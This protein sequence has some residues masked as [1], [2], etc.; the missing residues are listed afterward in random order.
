VFQPRKRL[1]QVRS[2]WRH[3]KSGKVKL[4]ESHWR[5]DPALG[6]VVKD[7]DMHLHEETT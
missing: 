4:I 1:H 6:V 7:Y 5:G 3:Y 2:F